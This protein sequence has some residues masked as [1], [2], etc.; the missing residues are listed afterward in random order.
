MR[1]RG[2]RAALG[3]AIG[4]IAVLAAPVAS[5]SASAIRECGN[6]GFTADGRGPMWTYRAVEGAG[7]Y[8]V[9]SRVVHC[10]TAR[11]VAL[12]AYPHHAYRGWSCRYVS[13]AE[14]YADIRCT[15]PGGRVVRF[16]AGA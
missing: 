16:Q 5:S 2:T 15:K 13:R 7:T 9:T 4:L 12:H 3:L 8:N 11:R 14:E 1:T 10:R 6:Y